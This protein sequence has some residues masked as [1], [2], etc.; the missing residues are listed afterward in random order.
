MKTIHQMIA[1]VIRREGGFNDVEGDAGGATNLG[2]SLKYAMGVGLDLDGD[3][4][5]DTD[6]IKIVTPEVAAQLYKRDFFIAPKIDRLPETIQPQV[7]DCAINHG[8][9]QAIKF[10][11]D[12]LIEAGF[13]PRISE[14]G[15]PQNDGVLGPKS[16]AAAHEADKAMGKFLNNAIMF[17]RIAFYERI[18]KLRPSQNKFLAGWLSR[19][20]EFHAA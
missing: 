6:D 19:A 5:T 7:F 16:I 10:V 14:A 1:D 18:V 17:E 2:V 13:M 3:G 4:D 9:P 20:K 12:V 8:A 11:Q 15:R